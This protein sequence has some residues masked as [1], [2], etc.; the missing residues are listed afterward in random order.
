MSSGAAWADA[1]ARLW[2][3]A[4][5]GTGS[6]TGAVREFAFLPNAERPR[7]LLPA[8]VPAAAAGALRRYSHDLGARQRVTRVLTTAAVRAGLAD[9]ALRDRLLVTGAGES[10]EDRLGALLGRPVVVSVG[11]GSERANRKPILHA[12]TPRGEPLAFVKVGDSP[13]ARELITG[14]AAALGRLAER[15]FHGLRVPQVLHHGEW[16]GL[17]LLVLSPLPTGPLSFRSRRDAP[18]AAMRELIGETRRG[19][20]AESGFWSRFG[21]VP[22]EDL[23][24]G[25]RLADAVGRIG[26]TYGG[27]EV[28]FGAWHGDWTPWNMAWHRGAVQLWDW[29]RYDPEVPAGL[30]LLHYRL[31]TGGGYDTWPDPAILAPLGQTGR[32]AAITTELYVLELTR[33][34]LVA[35]QGDL[36]T[37]LR[38][39][40]TTLL[41]L[42]YANAGRTA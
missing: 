31:Q 27:D 15:S 26:E 18:V 4:E 17:D 16:R 20:L 2:P 21:D 7:L 5:V 34:Y 39:Q 19:P 3:D 22:L 36:G 28:E 13:M 11:L 9:R 32:T 25:K 12:L 38:A 37:P 6:G 33:R 41:D 30:D 23:D 42:L 35:A 14:E 40:A 10:V 29:E 24:Q 1:V 8:G